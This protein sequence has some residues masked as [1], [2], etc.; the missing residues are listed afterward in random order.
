MVSEHASP[1][2]ALGGVDAGGQNVHVAELALALARPRRT[3]WSS[4]PG[5]TTP[6]CPAR[7]ARPAA[8]RS[9]HVDA[10]PAAPV[11]KDEPAAAHGR[12]R[13]AAGASLAAPAPP[14]VVHAPLLD[15]GARRSAP[16]RG[17]WAAGGAHLPRPGRR[18]AAPP[19][20]GRHEP[21]G[22]ARAGAGDRSPAADRIVATCTRRGVR[23]GAA[24]RRPAPAPSSPAASTS[25]ASGRTGRPSRARRPPARL[26]GPAGRAQGRRQRIA[27]A[28][29]ACPAPS[30]VVGGGPPAERLDADPE[31]RRLR[32]ASP[33]SSA[34]RTGS[35]CA[36]GIGRD[37][38]T[39]AAALGR[40]RRCACRGTSRSASSRS[41]PWP[42]ACR[43][44]HRGRRAGR[45]RRAT[46]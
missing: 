43:S 4:T 1:L 2:A 7:A 13:R 25:S 11:P 26:R 38:V 33:A 28:R 24:G 20:R 30:C 27:G 31:A 9:S 14:D 19:G 10:G 37:A 46:A 39:A 23:A 42:A 34:W 44:W 21:A 15:V 5:A 29:P 22:A 32:E 18:E 16:R 6:P 17:R 35:T 36:A 45:H 12:L 3:R 41:R 40:R 8:W